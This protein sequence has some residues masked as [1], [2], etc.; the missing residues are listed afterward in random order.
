MRRYGPE[1]VD[2]AFKMRC[3]GDVLCPKNSKKVCFSLLKQQ[4]NHAEDVRAQ[5]APYWWVQADEL[6]GTG[7]HQEASER[8]WRRPWAQGLPAEKGRTQGDQDPESDPGN[9]NASRPEPEPV[10]E[11]CNVDDT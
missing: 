6:G 7:S 10:E 5:G 1:V 9:E 11:A 3:F 2:L 8:P 4:L